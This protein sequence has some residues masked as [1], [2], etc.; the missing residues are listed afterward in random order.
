MASS[1]VSIVLFITMI[2][3]LASSNVGEALRWRTDHT[4]YHKCD[5]ACINQR[6]HDEGRCQGYCNH[7]CSVLDW[8][9]RWPIETFE[10]EGI[11]LQSY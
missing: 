2:V 8:K 5:I 7:Y 1:K 6:G 11:K 10:V 4:C 3:F 9:Y